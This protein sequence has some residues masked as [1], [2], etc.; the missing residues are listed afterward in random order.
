MIKLTF[1]DSGKATEAANIIEQMGANSN[2]TLEVRGPAVYFVGVQPSPALLLL[3]KARFGFDFTESDVTAIEGGSGSG[4]FIASAVYGSPTH[5][6]VCILQAW[7]DNSLYQTVLGRLCIKAYYK[8]SPH[9]VGLIKGRP[10][11]TKRI[12]QLLDLLVN[13][14]SRV[15]KESL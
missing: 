1:S 11:L 12:R 4:C 14:V 5:P 9:L 13:L 8:V 7:R 15:R 2:V 10:W 3:L 6:S